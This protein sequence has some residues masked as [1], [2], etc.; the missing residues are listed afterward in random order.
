MFVNLFSDSSVNNFRP[1]Y[2][3]KLKAIEVGGDTL[4]VPS[5]VFDTGSQR[6]T[7]I[8]SGT[9]LAYLPAEVYQP[10]MDKVHDAL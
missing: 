1:H 7:I 2:N 5:D 10:M 6:G 4:D 8:D 9:T 3:V